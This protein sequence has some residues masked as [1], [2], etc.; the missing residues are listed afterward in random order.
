MGRSHW[1]K[2]HGVW[3][4][5]YVA[6]VPLHFILTN[7]MNLILFAE[8][9][10]I[11]KLRRESNPSTWQPQTPLFAS[12]IDPHGRTLICMESATSGKAADI[13]SQSSWR[14]FQID[15]VMDFETVGVMAEFSGLLGKAEIPLMA[16][17]SFETDYLLVQEQHLAESLRVFRAAGHQVQIQA[18]GSH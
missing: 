3:Q 8:P 1:V 4:N 17:C 15:A 18:A 10:A 16:V 7:R 2:R 6:P 9:I 13:L 5:A 14:C 11:C 12:I